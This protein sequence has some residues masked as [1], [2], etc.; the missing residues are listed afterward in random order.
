MP[1]NQRLST[2][3]PAPYGRRPRAYARVFAAT[4]AAD[5]EPRG[6]PAVDL[7]IAAIALANDLPL[8]TANPSDFDHL[9]GVGLEVRGV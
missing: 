8:F 3:P 5:R 2:R 7:M 9:R 1:D 6:A 4:R